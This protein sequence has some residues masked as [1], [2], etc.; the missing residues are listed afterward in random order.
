MNR[1]LYCLLLL[2]LLLFAPGCVEDV[3]LPDSSGLV[4]ITLDHTLVHYDLAKKTNASSQS[5]IGCTVKTT[6]SSVRASA[7]TAS[8]WRWCG[9]CR[10]KTRRPCSS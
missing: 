6:C 9:T 4:G 10:R 2:P 1:P 3:W 5:T 7:P 8:A